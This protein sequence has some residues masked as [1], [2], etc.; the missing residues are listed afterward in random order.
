MTDRRFLTVHW[1][2]LFLGAA[3]NISVIVGFIGIPALSF[4]LLAG[5]RPGKLKKFN[6][7]LESHNLEVI[8]LVVFLAAV[9][10][11]TAGAIYL[12]HLA[13]GIVGSM[14]ESAWSRYLL[15]TLWH[16]MP[17]LVLTA[18]LTWAAIRS[19]AQ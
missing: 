12:I 2:A 4:V 7:Y 8:A 1:G 15:K 11:A 18:E 6:I 16:L 10:F 19:V 17:A 13:L 9:L 5:V 3:K 14:A